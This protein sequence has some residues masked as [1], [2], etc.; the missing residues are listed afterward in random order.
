MVAGGWWL[1]CVRGKSSISDI[2]GRGDG[3][4]S[5]RDV[6]KFIAAGH[7]AAFSRS[8]VAAATEIS[9][10]MRPIPKTGEPLPVVGL[11]TSG[12]F[13][14]PPGQSRIHQR[15]VLKRFF[16][17]GG[18]LIDT[19]PTYGD[20]ETVV[21]DLLRELSLTKQSFIATKV[22]ERG[23][24]AGVKQM[25]RSERRLGKKPIDLIQVHNLV[26]VQTQLKTLREWK[27]QG[28]IRYLGITHYRTPAF[29]DLARLMESQDLDFVQFNYSI[30]TPDAERRLLPLARDKGI[31]V[32]VNR[33]FED[34]AFFRRVRG[35][36][37][38]PWAA[39]F[40]C[41]SWAQY[42]LKYVLADNA[43]TCV[44]PATSNPRHL[45]DNMGAGKGPL[46]D[47]NTRR[48]MRSYLASM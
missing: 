18:T 31:A 13:E 19:S 1:N 42:A 33:A 23:R 22:H 40:D 20:A 29:D 34:G 6:L 46:P 47:A 4:L 12:T 17:L 21:G 32:L 25:E 7:L 16:A 48:R 26:D 2:G 5:R 24:R 15:E 8:H 43:V 38:P 14:V 27:A 10:I 9:I 30:E 11:G 39:D 37:L 28:R 44:I 3:G 36:P 41:R 35:K 45:V